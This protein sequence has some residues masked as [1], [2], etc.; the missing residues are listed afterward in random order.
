[1]MA[2]T[3]TIPPPWEQKLQQAQ[4]VNVQNIFIYRGGR[5]PRH[6]THVIIDKSIKI[7]PFRAFC[8]CEDLRYV[9]MHNGIEGIGKEAFMNCISLRGIDVTNVRVVGEMAFSRCCN[10]MALDNSERLEKIGVQ[11]FLDCSS[12][13]H[14]NLP[15][16]RVIEASG[17]AGCTN[18]M[19]AILGRHIEAIEISA[20]YY[21]TSLRRLRFEL[22]D[23]GISFASD[24]FD[25]CRQLTSIEL[26]G[27]I[28]QSISSLGLEEW[29]DDM[30]QEI[31][32]INH[33]LPNI[34]DSQKTTELSQWVDIV[35]SKI[36]CYKLMENTSLL[37]LALWKATKLVMGEGGSVWER[38]TCRMGCGAAVVIPNVLAFINSTDL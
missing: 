24:A 35:Q 32:R 18:M 29:Q 16:V 21:C 20:F 3:T 30:N 38:Q 13:G 10:L 15:S 17:F 22:G 5:A 12:L 23:N 33:L 14:V 34:H 31:D 9:K 1:M 37:E 25:C 2:T 6:V 36:E 27:N 4:E 28:H 8:C 7:I 19:C 11:A 26:V